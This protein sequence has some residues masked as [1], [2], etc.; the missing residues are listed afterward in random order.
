[1]TALEAFFW[2]AISASS[3][4]VGAWLALRFKP[5]TNLV[6]L[7][8]GLGAGALLGAVAFTL[9]PTA[10]ELVQVAPL[11][12]FALGAIVFYGTSRWIAKRGRKRGTSS[13]RKS[14]DEAK[15]AVESAS[16]L[17]LGILLD[18]IPESLV[19]GMSLFT[20]GKVSA[21]VL[22]A[23]IISN[24]PE[25]LGASADLL[26]AGVPHR[27]IYRLY[28]EICVLCALFASL[29]YLLVRG[30]P[31]ADGHLAEAFAAGAVLIMLANS[32]MPE[33]YREGRNMVGLMVVLGF[34]VSAA[35]AIL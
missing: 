11:V 16:S 35:L 2:G 7:F 10:E 20:G 23:V 21:D 29:G 6:G 13:P 28:G 22:A 24:I 25:A 15:Q 4:L 19:L 34:V 12:F 17:N 26:E 27:K 18:G 31:S 3:L 5:S 8:M 14:E 32:M 30:I 9:V 33:A 1:M